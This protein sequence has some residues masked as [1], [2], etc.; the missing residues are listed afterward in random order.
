M[1]RVDVESV[2][3]FRLVFVSQGTVLLRPSTHKRSIEGA[4][5]RDN[6][7]E[8][9]SKPNDDEKKDAAICDDAMWQ[10]RSGSEEGADLK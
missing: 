7:Q 10:A 9:D 4:D 5:R 3:P 2:T 6:G 8:S 1:R